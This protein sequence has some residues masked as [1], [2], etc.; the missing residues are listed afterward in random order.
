MCIPER[1]VTVADPPRISMDDTMIFV[2]SLSGRYV[3]RLVVVTTHDILPEK[4]EEKMGGCTPSDGDNFQ[5]RVGVGC[6]EFHFCRKLHR[7]AYSSI[8]LRDDRNKK[9]TMAKSRIWI[10]APEAYHQGPEIPYR[11]ATALD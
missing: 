8:F 5:E 1:A 11:Y 7:I 2:A 3:S 4:H 9:H 6:V 10:V